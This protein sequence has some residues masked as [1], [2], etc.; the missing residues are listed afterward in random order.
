MQITFQ[1]ATRKKAKLRLALVAPA[2]HGKTYGSLLIAKGLGGK[3][4]M[5]DTEAGRGE[6]YGNDFEYDIVTMSAPYSPE[7]YVTAIK[8]AEEAGYDNL[9]IDS[10]SHAWVGSGGVLDIQGKTVDTGKSN[11]FTAWRS[12]TPIHNQL[13][14]SIIGSK[15]H[16]IATMRAKPE[17]VIE[18]DERGASTIKKV[19]LAP[20]QRDGVDHEFTVV[21]DVDK[22]HIA[23]VSKDSTK[24]F[25]GKFSILSEDMGIQL[26]KW[27][28]EGTEDDKKK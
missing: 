19:G 26:K 23:S 15:C 2:G 17:Y 6:L 10:L 7:K 3:T 14:D 16:I 21:F 8:I 18:K 5:I 22:N 1:K 20:V 24:L 27:L 13:I 28:N 4:A 12:V 9:I 11:S 25:D